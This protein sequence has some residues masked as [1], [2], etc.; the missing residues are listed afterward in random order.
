[1]NGCRLIIVAHNAEKYIEKCISS[2][3]NQSFKNIEVIVADDC[4]TD[5]TAKIVAAY[6][7]SDAR[8]SYVCHETNKSALQARRTGMLKAKGDYLWFIDSDDFIK[9]GAC[10][11]LRDLTIKHDHPDM[12]CFGYEEHS[13]KGVSYSN[14]INKSLGAYSDPANNFNWVLYSNHVPWSRIVKKKVMEASYSYISEELYLSCA[15]DLPVFTISKYLSTTVTVLQEYLYCKYVRPG[16]ATTA[17]AI[18]SIRKHF[19]SRMTSWG[20]L[21]EIF[22]EKLD[23]DEDLKVKFLKKWKENIFGFKR[24]LVDDFSKNDAFF[25]V[26]DMSVFEL[27]TYEK[28][29]KYNERALDIVKCSHLFD[30]DWYVSEYADV[31]EINLTPEEH[32]VRY[33]ALLG[34]NPS[35]LFSSQIYSELYPDILNKSVNPLIHYI[36]VGKEEGRRINNRNNYGAELSGEDGLEGKLIIARRQDGFGERLKALINAIYVSNMTG[37]EFKF[38]WTDRLE[39]N[40]FHSIE[41]KDNIFSGEYIAKHHLEFKSTQLFLK[42]NT[43]NIYKDE[44]GLFET[45]DGWEVNQNYLNMGSNS[46]VLEGYKQAFDSIQFSHGIK[47]ALKEADMIVLPENSVA[48]HLRS[49]DIVFGHYRHSTRFTT[50]AIPVPIALE[51]IDRLK[52]DGKVVVVFSQDKDC[53]DEVVDDVSVFSFDYFLKEN[54]HDFIGAEQ[55]MFEIRLMSRC[56]F[57]ISGSSGFSVLAGRIGGIKNISPSEYLGETEQLRIIGQ[58]LGKVKGEHGNLHAA[59]SCLYACSLLSKEM[60]I[61]SVGEFVEKGMQ[62]DEGN[63]FFPLVLVGLLIKDSKLEEAEAIASSF[64]KIHLKSGFRPVVRT[65]KIKVSGEYELAD[66][67]PSY[68]LGAKM[69]LKYI[70]VIHGMVLAMDSKEAGEEYL[71]DLS[72]ANLPETSFQKIKELSLKNRLL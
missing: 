57:I 62:F 35:E 5:N 27:L 7:A 9:Q 14:Y 13:D 44:R 39:N 65:L 69:K 28:I 11:K 46:K 37:F 54:S 58:Y 30:R 49:G 23:I 59:Y 3:V 72:S 67:L 12:I 71:L 19:K 53:L 36:L 52:K 33:G 25:E 34:R 48:I 43:K 45:F 21:Y 68:S 60:S 64:I 22:F 2:C 17:N 63:I 31:V 18:S 10:E 4:S 29:S 20:V 32:Y 47:I 61:D 16:T 40:D 42:Y 55:E 8:V 66:Y 38:N 56:E 15:N 6:V 26:V 70:S 50:K 51:L 1:L 24:R 41:N